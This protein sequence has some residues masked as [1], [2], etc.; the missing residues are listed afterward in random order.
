MRELDWL[1]GCPDQ[2]AAPRTRWLQEVEGEFPSV[3]VKSRVLGQREQQL[4]TGK[5][6]LEKQKQGTADRN[7]LLLGR[8]PTQ[9]RTHLRPPKRHPKNHSVVE[10]I[11]GSERGNRVLEFAKGIHA[12]GVEQVAGTNQRPEGRLPHLG[13]IVCP[14]EGPA[15]PRRVHFEAVQEQ[16]NQWLSEPEVQGFG[17]DDGNPNK[18][19]PTSQRGKRSPQNSNPGV[20]WRLKEGNIFGPR[21]P[22][23][24]SPEVFSQ[25]QSQVSGRSLLGAKLDEVVGG[26]EEEEHST[27]EELI[28]Q[29][30]AERERQPVCPQGE[31]APGPGHLRRG[32]EIRI[33]TGGRRR[34]M[35]ETGGTDDLTANRGVAAG[36][37]G[38]PA[39]RD[40]QTA[41][42][43]WEEEAETGELHGAA[44]W[45]DG[46][47]ASIFWKYWLNKLFSGIRRAELFN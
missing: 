30:K 1:V 5:S 20:G 9:R 27:G 2:S 36:G 8:R 40:E 42:R 37:K 24:V 10:A 21:K 15:E 35:E 4:Q 47:T 25:K 18:A 46:R 45:D 34:D 6:G 11:E 23:V 17:E 26:R 14:N 13:S 39:G 33:G 31:I 7:R 32:A 44:G 43:E 16:S 22:P 29:I 3:P 12:A 19:K 41:V 28:E 38:L